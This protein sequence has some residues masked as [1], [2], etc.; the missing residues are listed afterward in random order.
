MNRKKLLKK[1]KKNK[2]I[3]PAVSAYI[4][5]LNQFRDEFNDYPEINFLLNHALMADHLLSLKQLPQDLPNLQ[6]PDDIQDQI[7]QKINQKYD[8]G[9]PEGDAE[10]D[11]LSNDLPKLD[12]QLRG[13]RDYLEE[14]YGMWA[15]IS[16][17]FTN[18]LAKFLDGK[19]TL[20]IMAG[21]GYISKGLKDHRANIITTD[22]L[23][24]QKENETGKH[25][26][27]PIEKLSALDAYHKYKDQVDYI[28]MC[29]SPDGV[30]IDNELLE[31]IRKDGNPVQL[32]VI[33]EKNGATNS[34]TFWQNAEF[35]KNTGIDTLNQ[36]YPHFDLIHDQVYLVK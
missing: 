32:I 11:K 2:Q 14:Q 25:Q 18:Q 29:W 28:I 23:E 34:K 30:P 16:S 19:P 17:S 21:N 5:S 36:Y 3:K 22:S 24:W 26:L 6:L 35:V 8:F 10:W 13:F 15:Y 4:Q 9:N 20:E 12:Q 1:M 7:Y 31:A 33:G 27:V